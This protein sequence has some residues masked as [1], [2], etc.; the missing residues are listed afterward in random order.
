MKSPI[1]IAS[2]P[3]TCDLI[4]EGLW[5]GDF[6][7]TG[8]D[9]SKFDDVV[10][11]TAEDIPPVH[12]QLGGLWLY[13]PTWDSGEVN[14]SGVRE[15]AR[16]VANRVREGKRVLVHCAAGLNRSGIVSAR[17][18]MFM[19]YE[20]EDAIARVRERREGALFN[21]TFVEWLYKEGGKTVP[22][23]E[24]RAY[25]LLNLLARYDPDSAVYDDEDAF[26]NAVWKGSEGDEEALH[27]LALWGVTEPAAGGAANEV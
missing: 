15:A 4:V 9:W 21:R 20:V 7:E 18:L 12:L 17:A 27:N 25:P 22:E 23:S 13:V 11:M 2:D 8:V 10:T 19:G 16:L 24:K 14:E 3:F 26:W 6:P 5:Q 1:K